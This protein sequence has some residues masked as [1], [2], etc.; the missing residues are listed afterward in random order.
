MLEHMVCRECGEVFD[1]DLFAEDPSETFVCPMCG[2]VT[3]DAEPVEDRVPHIHTAETA[4]A[5]P[6]APR[7]FSA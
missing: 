6:R 2:T 7:C 3:L 4:P 5:E 1:E